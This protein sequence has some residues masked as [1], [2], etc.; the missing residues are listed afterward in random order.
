MAG[1]SWL[2]WGFLAISIGSILMAGALMWLQPKPMLA[3]QNPATV[4]QVKPARTEV[5]KPLIVERNGDRLIWRLQ[6]DTAEQQQDDMYLIQPRLELFTETGEV[7][8]V[9]GKEAWFEPSKK[10]IRF[11]GVVIVKHREWTLETEA[12]RYDS[13]LDLIDIPGTFEMY[14][15]DVKMHGRTMKIDRQTQQMTVAHDVW[16][17]DSR[18]SRGKVQ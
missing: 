6:A 1:L 7:V 15:K 12:L 14:R 13:E 3:E 16:I 11:K 9:Q 8:P 10:N 2:K 5:E 18:P 17:Q 4:E